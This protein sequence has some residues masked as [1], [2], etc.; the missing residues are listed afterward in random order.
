MIRFLDGKG[1]L[2]RFSNVAVLMLVGVV[3]MAAACGGG[4][5]NDVVEVNTRFVEAMQDYIIS[6]D[7][8]TSAKEVA[9]AIN[10]YADKI[11]TL[12][13]EMK[14]V[15]GKFPEVASNEDIPDELKALQQKSEELQQQVVGSYM[16]MMKYMMD[17][18][19][20][21]AHKRLQEAMMKMS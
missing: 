11:E 13:P 1:W 19:V 20:Q 12:A 21:K 10:R 3:L 17:T 18:E 6:L 9:G 4:K 14:A 15:R 16:N 8:A 7:K 2:M 5:Y